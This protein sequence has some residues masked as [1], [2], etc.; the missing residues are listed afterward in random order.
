MLESSPETVRLVPEVGMN[1]AMAVPYAED[2]EDV[3][4]IPGRLIK[5]F[6][7]VKATSNP[8]FGASAHLAKYILEIIRHDPS[9]RAAI[10]LKFSERILSLLERKNLAV[11]FYDRSEEPEEL[12]KIEGKTIPWGVKQAIERIGKVPNVIYHRGD[13]GKEPMI[14]ILGEEAVELARFVL[15]IAKEVAEPEP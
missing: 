13:I 10:N 9:K 5:V 8:S 14:V 1:I 15:E 7:H 6:N 2:L 12:K 4:A 3:A 11:S